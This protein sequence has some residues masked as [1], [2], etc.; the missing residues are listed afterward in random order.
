MK[1]TKTKTPLLKGN[2]YRIENYEDYDEYIVVV[3]EGKF[4]STQSFPW[5]HS[6]PD[7]DPTVERAKKICVDNATTSLVQYLNTQKEK[8]CWLMRFIRRE[9]KYM[10]LMWG[11]N[12]K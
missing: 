6:I 5:H 9:F 1:I 10:K 11:L 2:A 7:G 4:S 3:S 12:S 8:E